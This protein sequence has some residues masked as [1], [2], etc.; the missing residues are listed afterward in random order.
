[1]LAAGARR[2][3]YP[4]P[5]GGVRLEETFPVAAPATASDGPIKL[6]ILVGPNAPAG[7]GR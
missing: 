3:L 4:S 6:G 2:F 5:N 1:L 7:Q